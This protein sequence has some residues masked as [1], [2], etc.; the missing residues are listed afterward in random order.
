[1]TSRYLKSH[2]SHIFGKYEFVL[3][4]SCR[5]FGHA[6]FDELSLLFAYNRVYGKPRWLVSCPKRSGLQ[7]N[8]DFIVNPA[9][10]TFF[11]REENQM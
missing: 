1:M 9:Y 6:L 5:V 10:H 2:K 7:K 3:M 11:S 8:K 4:R